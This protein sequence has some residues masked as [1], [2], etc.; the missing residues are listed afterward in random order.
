M[1]LPLPP[2]P[3]PLPLPPP[4]TSP[5]SPSV[6]VRGLGQTKSW[7]C[8]VSNGAVL[9]G[10]MASIKSRSK[11]RGETR[12]P[13]PQTPKPQSPFRSH[14]GSRLKE[15]LLLRVCGISAMLVIA[16][17]GAGSA[18]FV[19][20]RREETCTVSFKTWAEYVGL[21]IDH[22]VCNGLA[23]DTVCFCLFFCFLSL[24]FSGS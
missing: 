1:G 24:F 10:V 5:P 14:F 19:H 15:L 20:L 12:N 18:K 22:P 6:G 7:K 16:N 23:E 11:K 2:S 21:G 3:V 8:S 13:T 4:L 17:M 9:S